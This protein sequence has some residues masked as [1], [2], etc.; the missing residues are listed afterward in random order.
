MSA[1]GRKFQHGPAVE[2]PMLV[3]HYLPYHAIKVGR[4]SSVSIATRYGLTVWG[5]NPRGGGEIFRNRPDR[6]WGPTSLLYNRYR[7]FL[8]VKRSGRR[9]DHPPTSS[10]EV[11]ER[12][13][14]YL[15]SPSWFLWPV[16]PIT[17]L[18]LPRGRMAVQSTS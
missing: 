12:V 5:S 13:E 8:R 14:L 15:Y 2:V 16:H 1:D 9:V 10:A 7:S 6:P 3:L 11:K 17:L 18:T 4:D